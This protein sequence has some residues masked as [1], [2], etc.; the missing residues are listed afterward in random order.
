MPALLKS[1]DMRGIDIPFF[2]N[3]SGT[4]DIVGNAIRLLSMTAYYVI[5]LAPAAL[6][7]L[8]LRSSDRVRFIG[9][10]IVGVSYGLGFFL[11]RQYFPWEDWLRPL[12]LLMFLLFIAGLIEFVRRRKEREVAGRQLMW[13]MMICFGGLMLLKMIL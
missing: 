11:A 10:A 5:A 1:C 6:V 8:S 7:A 12:P 13:L 2:R 3:V 4:N 9:A